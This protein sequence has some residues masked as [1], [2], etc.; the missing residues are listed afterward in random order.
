MKG[1]G[2]KLLA[3]LVVVAIVGGFTAYFLQQQKITKVS[4][5]KQVT[6]DTG[7]SASLQ[8]EIVVANPTPNQK[9]ESPLSLSGKARGNWYFEGSFTAELFDSS[10]KSLGTVVVSANGEW[11]TE[12]FVP[13]TG[14]LKFEKP[15]T[16]KGK[17]V[18]KKDNPSGLPENDKSLII[19]VTF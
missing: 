18:I 17:L 13:F 7:N 1:S 12:D 19:P 5:N 11:M 9:I 10:N 8:S 14:E 2:I 16:S 4:S 3:L 15:T 6:E